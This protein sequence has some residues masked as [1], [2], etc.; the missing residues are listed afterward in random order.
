MQDSE[1]ADHTRL[2]GTISLKL[3]SSRRRS[4]A[5]GGSGVISLGSSSISIPLSFSVEREGTTMF[6]SQAATNED[7]LEGSLR[8]YHVRAAAP[9]RYII[10]STCYRIW[11]FCKP[12]Q[13]DSPVALRDKRHRFHNS[14]QLAA[15]GLSVPEAFAFRWQP[16]LGKF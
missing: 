13:N 10:R 6:P 7:V 16:R 14:L 9:D 12:R 1:K 8:F 3:S 2:S 11:K 15:R 4:S 5:Y